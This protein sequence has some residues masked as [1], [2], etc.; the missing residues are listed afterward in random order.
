MENTE[1]FRNTEKTYSEFHETT[2][3]G[4]FRLS[5]GL[6]RNGTKFQIEKKANSLYGLL[7]AAMLDLKSIFFCYIFRRKFRPPRKVVKMEK[8]D[9]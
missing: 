9:P 1:Y 5:Q 7:N 3:F 6:S 4:N 8:F 2:K